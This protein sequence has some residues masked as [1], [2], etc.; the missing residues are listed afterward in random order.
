[1]KA[2]L[3]YFIHSAYTN[4]RENSVFLRDFSAFFKFLTRLLYVVS[5]VKQSKQLL[6]QEI[7]LSLE[8]STYT[9]PH[10]NR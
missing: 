10:K 8:A 1:M 7:G 6:T 3:F 5:Q 9:F 2:S 4:P